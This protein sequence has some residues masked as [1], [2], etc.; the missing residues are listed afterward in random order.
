V[1]A[2]PVDTGRLGSIVCVV[3][4]EPRVNPETG[5]VR[6]DR[7]GNTIFVVGVVV[8]QLEGRRAEVI[9]VAV[10]GEPGDVTEGMPVKITDLTAIQW[11]MGDRSGTSFRATAISPAS[12]PVRPGV[13]GARKPN[14][15]EG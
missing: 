3:G 9:E 15:A 7:D 13:A 12:G 6:V 5:Q 1:Q 10:P 2:I 8:R 4:P 14:G 11:Q